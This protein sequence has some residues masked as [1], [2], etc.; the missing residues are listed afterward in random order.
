[1]RRAVALLFPIL[2]IA[3][4]VSA[5]QPGPQPLVGPIDH[6]DA[7]FRGEFGIISRVMFP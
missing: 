7:A 5:Q 1:M 6:F 4:P 2:V 3:F